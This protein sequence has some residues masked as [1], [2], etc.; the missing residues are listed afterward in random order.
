[1]LGHAGAKSAMDSM[2]KVMAMELGPM[3]ITVNVV[4]PGL[5]LTDASRTSSHSKMTN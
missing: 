3:G 2:A 5:T 1:M 4:G